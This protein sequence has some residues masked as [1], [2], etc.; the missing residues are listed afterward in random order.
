MFLRILTKVVKHKDLDLGAEVG[1]EKSVDAL[2]DDARSLSRKAY[3]SWLTVDA[4]P[5]KLF[6]LTQYLPFLEVTSNH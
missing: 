2:C 6:K 3:A 4:N 1:N 5:L